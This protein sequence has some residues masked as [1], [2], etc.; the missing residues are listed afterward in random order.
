[1]I[2]GLVVPQFYGY[3]VIVALFGDD[4]DPLSHLEHLSEPCGDRSGS[5]LYT[6]PAQKS[7]T[8]NECLECRISADK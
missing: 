2:L 6:C 8:L 5:D 3:K 4:N 7:L 1:M